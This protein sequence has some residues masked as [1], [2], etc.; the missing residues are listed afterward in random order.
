MQ[1]GGRAPEPS[2]RLA[3]R[4]T[5]KG[6]GGAGSSGQPR[7]RARRR[8]GSRGPPPGA[9]HRPDRA[10]M[11]SGQGQSGRAVPWMLG[12]ARGWGGRRA[13]RGRKGDHCLGSGAAHVA[14]EAGASSLLV[15]HLGMDGG[16]GRRMPRLGNPA[17]RAPA[18]VSYS[19]KQAN[20]EERKEAGAADPCRGPEGCGGRG[21]GES[22]PRPCAPG[23]RH[24]KRA[25]GS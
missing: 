20:L 3:R 24:E 12:C 4:L 2:P 21:V 25:A 8:G 10:T 14:G 6:V 15:L 19:G 1:G 22:N 23:G 18:R 13:G 11:G 5:W 16:G 7:L 9:R 17:E